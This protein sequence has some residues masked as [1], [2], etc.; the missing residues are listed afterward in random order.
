MS[1]LWVKPMIDRGTYETLN[2]D[3]VWSLSATMQARPVYMKFSECKRESLLNWLWVANSLDLILDF[4]LTYVS[5][6]FN[7][8]GPFFLKRILDSLDTRDED[9]QE[10][11]KRIS[12]AYIYAFLSFLCILG[13]AEA[14]VQHLWF[15]RRAATRM[16]TSL[17]TA[18][19][20]KALKRKDFSGITDKDGKANVDIKDAKGDDPKA[21]ADVGKIVNLMAGDANKVR[22]PR[23]CA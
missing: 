18:I 21:G 6:I 20:D 2:E 14:D 12:Q 11:T 15:G 22:P 1:F 4:T 7:Y 23:L 16:R 19:Y 5:V 17:M 3:D 10:R 13:R 8:L 9:E